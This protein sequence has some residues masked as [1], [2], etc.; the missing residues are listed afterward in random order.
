MALKSFNSNSH[1]YSIEYMVYSLPTDI[2][3]FCEKE[4]LHGNTLDSVVSDCIENYEFDSFPLQKNRN[5]KPTL[6]GISDKNRK[7]LSDYA[8]KFNISP[9]VILASLLRKKSRLQKY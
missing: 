3:R 5:W 1:S 2:Q 8:T 9:D 7:V 6:F 4:K